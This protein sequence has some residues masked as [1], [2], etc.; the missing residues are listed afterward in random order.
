MSYKDDLRLNEWHH[1]YLGLLI[2]ALGLTF[3]WPWWIVAKGVLIAL[4]DILQHTVQAIT[5][6]E[7]K[8]PMARLYAWVYK[9]SAL[10]RRVNIW[11]DSLFA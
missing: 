9:R 5:K 6:T 3:G 10:V 2:V 4:D 11:L 1:G 7:W 8:S